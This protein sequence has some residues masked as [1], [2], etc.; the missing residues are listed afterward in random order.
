MKQTT[1][2]L[3][4]DFETQCDQA[5]TTLPTEVGAVLMRLDRRDNWRENV[6][7]VEEQYGSL[8]W[9][10]Q[11]PPQTEKI[12]ELTGIDDKMLFEEGISRLLALTEV[13][14]LIEKAEV[15]F[16]HKTLF[17]KTVLEFNARA[18]GLAVPEKE[19][20]CTLSN[21]PWHRSLTCRKLSHLAYEHDVVHNKE[22][23]HRAVG[24]VELMF[25][26]IAKYPID[27]VL[28]YARDPWVYL[29][30]FPIEPWKDGEV[31]TSMAKKLEFTWQQVKYGE[32]KQFP[33]MW[34]KRVK[35]SE[36]AKAMESFST[37]PFRVAKVEGIQ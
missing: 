26:T 3:G 35:A 16:A 12:V 34:V 11:Y 5:K 9:E 19:W 21:F 23:L 24:D 15:V 36:Y 7:T 2:F 28:A 8:I 6:W 1:H 37:L 31:Q 18:V 25:K 20:I 32:D 10:V 13:V 27:E 30:A 17:D 33:K 4:I 14:K 22:D 29:R